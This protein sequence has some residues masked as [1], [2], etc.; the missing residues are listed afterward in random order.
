MKL[1]KRGAGFILGHE[2][3][4]LQAYRDPA[5]VLTIGAGHT[6]AAG[7]L[8]PR[9]GMVISLSKALQIFADDMRTYEGRVIAAIKARCRKPQYR[10]DALV[11]FDFNTG[12]I[13]EGSVDDKLNRG[14]VDA[15][16]ATL[17]LYVNAGGRRLGGLVKRRK[18][19]SAL[20]LRGK[21]PARKILLKDRAKAQGRWIN[22][23]SMPW[24]G[25]PL[26]IDK[27][28]PAP[29]LPTKKRK[30]NF[31]LDLATFLARQ[32]SGTREGKETCSI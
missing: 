18:E 6:A 27:P 21:Y 8:K 1:S 20:Y 11:S 4:Y 19:E 23:Q 14:D 26:E 29:P 28:V 17:R 12:A 31:I 9:P 5:G 30:P 32:F 16:M 22:P 10:F 15:G 3:I 13:D 25:A 2:A 24:Q 7:G